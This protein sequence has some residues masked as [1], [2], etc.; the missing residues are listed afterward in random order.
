MYQHSLDLK[1]ERELLAA[2]AIWEAQGGVLRI[3]R[4]IARAGSELDK[5]QSLCRKQARA[6]VAALFR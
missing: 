3:F 5:Q 6:V 4:E 1:A 2:E